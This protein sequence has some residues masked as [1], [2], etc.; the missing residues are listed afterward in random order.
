MDLPCFAYLFIQWWTLGLFLPSGWF[1]PYHFDSSFLLAPLCHRP[2]PSL[3]L[4]LPPLSFPSLVFQT[5]PFTIVPPPPIDFALKC[6]GHL[7]LLL[8]CPESHRM[9]SLG[10]FSLALSC[11]QRWVLHTISSSP[12]P[13]RPCCPVSFLPFAHASVVSPLKY[14]WFLTFC[15]QRFFLCSDS[16]SE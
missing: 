8:C 15:P 7:P 11:L 3:P 10:S 6:I 14:W 12:L 13:G 1:E 4:E 9:P 5:I 2:Q 16:A